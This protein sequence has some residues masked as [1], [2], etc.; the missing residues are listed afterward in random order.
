MHT[1]NIF[2]FKVIFILIFLIIG[3]SILHKANAQLIIDPAITNQG[4]ADN[5]VK[6]VLIGKGVIATNIKWS[7]NI[8]GGQIASFTTGTNPTNLGIEKGIVLSTGDVSNVNII[9]DTTSAGTDWCQ[10]NPG[11]QNDVDLDSIIKFK[12]G[13]TDAAV[14]EFDFIP[15]STP[16]KFKYVF[17]SKE[18]PFFVCSMRILANGDTIRFN[19]AFAFLLS[20]KDAVSGKY[21]KNRNIAT[22]PG[23]NPVLPVAIYTI[24]PGVPGTDLNGTHW[25][26]AGCKSLAYKNLYIANMHGTTVNFNGFTTVLTAQYD[27]IPCE[28]Y[29]LK[30]AIADVGDG[31]RDSG[32]FLEASSLT[33]FSAEA[34]PDTT[35][36]CGDAVTLK[37]KTNYTGDRKS[38]V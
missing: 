35:I 16:I 18:Y 28:T 29:H 32:V 12:D 25:T 2:N 6:K 5:I 14:L 17:A 7:D 19:D 33:S 4:E 10:G 23:S 36:F 30:I 22:V 21:S 13:T 26:A 27:V 11:C 9:S 37:C 38:V 3:L 34:F 24:N 31:T 1:R 15:S 20:K 8:G